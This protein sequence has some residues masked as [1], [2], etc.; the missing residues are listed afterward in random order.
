MK[1]ISVLILG[2]AFVT[3]TSCKKEEKT[4]TLT[5]TKEKAE[6]IIDDFKMNL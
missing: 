1:K 6:P 4:E 3:F 5:E 2:L